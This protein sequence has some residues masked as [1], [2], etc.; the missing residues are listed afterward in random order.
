MTELSFKASDYV[1][2]AAGDDD[3]QPCTHVVASSLL[4]PS[5]RMNL[6]VVLLN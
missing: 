4:L 3:C 2:A 6:V 1:L 5:N